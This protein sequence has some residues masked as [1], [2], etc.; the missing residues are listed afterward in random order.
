[1]RDLKE[2]TN[3][4]W[5]SELK[6]PPPR[7]NPAL[8]ALRERLLEALTYAFANRR[9]E[10]EAGLLED[11]VQEALL[12]IRGRL[13]TFRGESR[14]LTWATKVAVSLALTELR[15]RRWRD[16]S[17]DSLESAE[18]LFASRMKG[19][20]EDMVQKDL[21]AVLERTIRSDLT[22]K[23]RM[24][25]AAVRLQGMPLDEVAR[26]MGTNRNSVYKLL[27]DARRRLKRALLAQGLTVQEILDAFR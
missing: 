21:L 5:L 24:A 1:M 17:L 19:P 7:C 27:F 15:R 4:E 23:Q 13:D 2:R 20:E 12:R 25:L 3:Q 10:L 9:A 16:V 22:E 8:Q 18:N 14:F 6:L 26:R 11:L